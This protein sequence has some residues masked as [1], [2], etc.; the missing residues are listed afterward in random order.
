MPVVCGFERTHD[1]DSERD[2]VREFTLRWRRAFTAV[3]V[4]PGFDQ[5]MVDFRFFFA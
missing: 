4:R 2:R 3:S 1:R 5:A